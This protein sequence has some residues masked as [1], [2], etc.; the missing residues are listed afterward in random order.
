MSVKVEPS[1]TDSISFL[2][3]ALNTLVGAMSSARPLSVIL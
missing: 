1:P 3:V 2:T